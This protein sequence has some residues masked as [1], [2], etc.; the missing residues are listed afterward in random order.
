M[1]SGLLYR[2]LAR[3]L[4]VAGIAVNCVCLLL[5]VFTFAGF[6]DSL[7]YVVW[8]FPVF[9]VLLVWMLVSGS[10]VLSRAF[11][12]FATVYV[13][14]TVVAFIL[15]VF[16]YYIASIVYGVIALALMG[17]CAVVPIARF[18]DLCVLLAYRSL[19]VT[20]KAEV[21]ANWRR[22]ATAARGGMK[23][24]VPK[25]N[26]KSKEQKAE[27]RTGLDFEPAGSAETT[28]TASAQSTA[29][30][31]TAGTQATAGWTA[32]QQAAP[33]A[34]YQQARSQQGSTVQQQAG[35]HQTATTHST[36]QT[37]TAPTGASPQESADKV[38]VNSC[39]RDAFLALPGFSIA[40]ASRAVS[41]RE[42]N[43]PYRSVDDFVARNNVK[44]HFAIQ[45]EGLISVETAA[46]SPTAASKRPRGRGLD[47]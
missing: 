8:L 17:V 7:V 37:A 24:S 30:T 12:G 3:I 23:F 2:V 14:S 44:P 41:E 42:Q 31:S 11:K 15:Y 28:G 27:R 16:L 36:V 40:Q 5:G 35:V 4:A 20:A 18:K 34:G 38:A 32:Q 19:D 33:Q 6:G 45:M 9:A 22:G 29:A 21:D 26:K 13:L 47:L 39:P 1:K 43:G 10:E 46:K 25:R